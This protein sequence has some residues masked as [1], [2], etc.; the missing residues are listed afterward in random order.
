MGDV[1]DVRVLTASLRRVIFLLVLV[2]RSKLVP[3]FALT[4][5]LIHLI[6][7]SLYSRALPSNWLWWALQ[8]ASATLMTCLGIWSC[9]WRELRPINFGANAGAVS[10]EHR[11][12]GEAAEVDD[13][14]GHGRGRGRGK[15]RDGG[16]EYEMVGMKEGS[17]DN[18]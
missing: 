6:I 11:A 16:G 9:Q 17:E 12:S 14:V 4:I 18:V 5:H 7:T 8:A 13:G 3:D 1:L 10:S 15:G 2:S